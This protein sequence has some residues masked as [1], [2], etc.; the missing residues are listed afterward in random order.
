MIVFF[1][2]VLPLCFLSTCPLRPVTFPLLFFIFL[3]LS[4]HFPFLCF[5]SLLLRSIHF[6]FAF[7]YFPFTFSLISLYFPFLSLISLYFPF[8]FPLLPFSFLL[9]PFAFHLLPFL[10]EKREHW[11]VILRFWRGAAEQY[12]RHRKAYSYKINF[13]QAGIWLFS[14]PLCLCFPSTCLLRTLHF[15]FTVPWFAFWMELYGCGWLWFL[16]FVFFIV[17]IVFKLF[18]LIVI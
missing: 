12:S 14:F 6:R 8:P 17:F 3:S 18:F 1:S 11:C 4:L 7:L 10:F 2:F 9:L 13:S 15:L 16:C 5:L